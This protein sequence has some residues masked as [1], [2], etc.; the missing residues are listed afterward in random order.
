VLRKQ[1]LQ[2]DSW[3]LHPERARRDGRVSEA[4]KVACGVLTPMRIKLAPLVWSVIAFMKKSCGARCLR[5]HRMLSETGTPISAA[6]VSCLRRRGTLRVSSLATPTAMARMSWRMRLRKA[7][8][9][10]S[11]PPRARAHASCANVASGDPAP[12]IHPRLLAPNVR[13]GSSSNQ[14]W[15]SPS[16][17]PKQY[18]ARTVTMATAPRGPARSFAARSGPRPPRGSRANG[19]SPASDPARARKLSRIAACDAEPPL[20]ALALASSLFPGGTP[21]PPNVRSILKA[22]PAVFPFALQHVSGI[23]TVVSN[24][25]P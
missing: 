22:H 18:Y 3:N 1:S 15:R 4:G 2:I 17:Y 8:G 11:A 6:R 20:G 14:Y 7:R 19:L 25:R 12:V 13:H 10:R 23:Q 9:Q 5:R 16:P 21:G 24:L